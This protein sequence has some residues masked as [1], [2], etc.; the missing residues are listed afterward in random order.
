MI[1]Q[2]KPQKGRP[3]SGNPLM[4]KSNQPAKKARAKKETPSKKTAQPA[5][6]YTSS[7]ENK[8]NAGKIKRYLPSDFR[9][10]T[11]TKPEYFF[12]TDLPEAYN[13]TY[14]KALPC[15]P[16][17]VFVFWEITPN[18]IENAQ[19]EIGEEKFHLAKTILRIFDIT[20]RQNGNLSNAN[21]FDLDIIGYKNSRHLKLPR[22][23]STYLIH[24]GL[25]LPDGSFFVLAQ[26]NEV[27]TP[28]NGISNTIDEKWS[29]AHTN[30]LITFSRKQ[31]FTTP[32]TSRHPVPQG[33]SATGE[34]SSEFIGSSGNLYS[35][36]FGSSPNQ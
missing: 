17:Q 27:K 11:T 31:L 22:P 7:S 3:L 4:K 26:S 23:S 34:E 6:I 2:E 13:K 18:S 19:K 36:D 28:Q 1:Q 35:A 21:H 29:N 8:E 33:K 32:N 15:N 14:L 12:N 5:I 10:Q 24:F 9:K 30:Q 16:F 25:L 20:D